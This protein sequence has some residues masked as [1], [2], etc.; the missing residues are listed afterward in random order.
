MT[1]TD[2]LEYPNFDYIFRE[3]V[4]NAK[5][6][7]LYL[8]SD[9]KNKII[10]STPIIFI[11]RIL[12]NNVSFICGEFDFSKRFDKNTKSNTKSN[13][14]FVTMKI[15]TKYNRVYIKE[16]YILSL[17]ELDSYSYEWFERLKIYY[18]GLK[19]EYKSFEILK[20]SVRNCLNDFKIEVENIS[21]II[22]ESSVNISEEYGPYMWENK[23][24]IECAIKFEL[25]IKL[26][27]S[28]IKFRIHKKLYLSNMTKFF[29][30]VNEKLIQYTSYI[31][32]N[33]KSEVN[34]IKRKLKS[35]DEIT[36]SSIIE[37][38]NKFITIKHIDILFK[39]VKKLI[40]IAYINQS[41]DETKIRFYNLMISFLN[42][43]I[44]NSDIL[45]TDLISISISKRKTI[46]VRIICN[47]LI[48]YNFNNDINLSIHL[49]REPKK[50]EFLNLIYNSFYSR[51][52]YEF[53]EKQ[54]ILN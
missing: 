39:G 32:T 21:L 23:Y 31:R 29:D 18:S 19:L 34:F 7:S 8:L 41:D 14:I 52:S 4:I 45:I 46:N 12:L 16:M 9:D 25:E 53:F 13:K 38:R 1:N 37:L 33:Y 36:I 15:F 6:Y 49:Y 54:I 44:N 51:L 3:L 48:G 40:K 17:K 42:N 26:C 47:G 5:C 11:E 50:L 24:N 22:P 43:K 20:S 27:N 28:E 30:M 2:I 10:K 35:D